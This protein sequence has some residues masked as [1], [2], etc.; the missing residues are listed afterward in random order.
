MAPEYLSPGVYVEEVDHKALVLITIN[1]RSPSIWSTSNEVSHGTKLASPERQGLG[2]RI[3]A[4]G[5]P[6][7]A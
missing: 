1:W 7:K 5:S 4:H 6:D 2:F 3:L